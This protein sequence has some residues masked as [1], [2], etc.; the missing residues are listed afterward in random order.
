MEQTYAVLRNFVAWG[1]GL[2]AKQITYWESD[3]LIGKWHGNMNRGQTLAHAI[4]NITH[5]AA[6]EPLPAML[7]SA[8]AHIL[9]DRGR[10]EPPKTPPVLFS[11]GRG[12][13]SVL[14]VVR[15]QLLAARGR[16]TFI[17]KGQNPAGCA[18]SAPWQAPLP[19]LPPTKPSSAFW[20]EQRLWGGARAPYNWPSFALMDA[21]AKE[22]LA[23]GPDAVA[24]MLDV[25]PLDYR[26]DAHLSSRGSGGSPHHGK[27]DC[28]HL[29][30]GI[31]GGPLA[32]VPRLLLHA[33]VT[34]QI[35]L[36]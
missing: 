19:R 4:G 16:A 27:P 12:F 8:G 13:K 11:K 3:T 33:L 35:K 21:I 7:V 24:A 1:S 17:W 22:T 34:T 29:C 14:R 15:D 25:T 2:C 10:D 36:L 6:T 32:L 30:Y 26:A 31:D 18:V 23:D 5:A 28:L 20:E 9:T